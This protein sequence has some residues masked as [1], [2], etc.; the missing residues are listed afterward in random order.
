M[1]V[2]RQSLHPVLEPVAIV[3]ICTFVLVKQV[4]LFFGGVGGASG[5]RWH[6]VIEAVAIAAGHGREA[7][8]VR[9]YQ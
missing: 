2:D 9:L 5:A 8:F 6:R 7:V 4:T 1:S 3:S